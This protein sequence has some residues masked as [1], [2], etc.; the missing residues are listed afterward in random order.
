MVKST[1]IARLHAHKLREAQR[2][3][4]SIKP[5]LVAISRREAGRPA[6]ESFHNRS[7]GMF[8]ALVSDG[9]GLA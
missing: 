8:E 7:R 9:N 6:R 4:E 3:P 5:H 1:T 2:Q